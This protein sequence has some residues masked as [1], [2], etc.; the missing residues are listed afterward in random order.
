MRD[1]SEAAIRTADAIPIPVL[2]DD[3]AAQAAEASDVI[4]SASTATV[5]PPPSLADEPDILSAFGDAVAAAGLQ[6]EGRAARLCYLVVTS[7]LLERPVSLALKGPSA[8]GK[9]YLLETVLGFFPPSAYYALSAMSER[10]LAYDREPLRH[11]MLVL[12]E[13]AGLGSEFASY[14]VRSLLS[15]GRVRYVTVEKTRSG[16]QSR[17]I[18]R[19]GPTGLITTT[20]SIRLHPENETRLLSL[21][22]TDSPEQTKAVLLAQARPAVDAGPA[23]ERWQGFQSWL[24]QASGDAVIPYAEQLAE[25]I[26]P[27]AVRLRRDFPAVLSLIRAHALLHQATRSRDADG[28]VVA[29]RADYLAVRD[30]VGDLI[31]DGAEQAVPESTRQT[32]AAVRD[33]VGDSVREVTVQ[34]V[35]AALGI[36]KSAASRRVRVAL[37]RGYLRN[38]EER[39]GRP[40]R[41]VL[42]DPLPHDVVVLPEPERL[43]G[44]GASEGD[45]D[46]ASASQSPGASPSPAPAPAPPGGADDPQLSDW[47][48]APLPIAEVEAPWVQ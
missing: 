47:L 45:R 6:G 43:H 12:Y 32:V 40:S 8:A 38:L 28:R 11:R 13:A 5:Q 15:E 29:T 3:S 16:L 34:E 9:S 44:C 33:C 30:L 2:P 39:R 18:E 46:G 7:R 25:L 1:A 36:D 20:T 37:E 17:T 35:A 48:G 26:P 31:A 4:P 19:E 24:E 10:A 42:G 41:L 23:Q 14:L 22:I 27:V 21:T